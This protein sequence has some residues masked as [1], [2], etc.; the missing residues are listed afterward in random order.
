MGV[1]FSRKKIV[2]ISSSGRCVSLVRGTLMLMRVWSYCKNM[3]NRKSSQ[4]L[5][6]FATRW[7]RIWLMNFKSAIVGQWMWIFWYKTP[8]D[9]S[10]DYNKFFSSCTE[11]NSLFKTCCV[12]YFVVL[13]IN[14]LLKFLIIFF[15]F[16]WI[17]L[18]TFFIKSA[19]KSCKKFFLRF[20][21]YSRM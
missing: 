2:E 1:F 12:N 21:L 13:F 14:N 4:I 3:G 10:C 8:K 9:N 11:K 6:L 19:A 5:L 20:Y 7:A 16:F 18:H 17:G 15:I